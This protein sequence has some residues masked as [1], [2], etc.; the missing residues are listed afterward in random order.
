LEGKI[1]GQIHE[2]FQ[3]LG[4]EA[5][6]RGEVKLK[7]AHE[8]WLHGRTMAMEHAGKLGHLKKELGST[9]LETRALLTRRE[10]Q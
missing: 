3:Q 2:N 10:V 9:W 8:V 7:D 6:E 1:A 5:A 4:C